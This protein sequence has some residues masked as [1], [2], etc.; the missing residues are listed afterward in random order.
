MNAD[1]ARALNDEYARQQ[2]MDEESINKRIRSA[3]RD[4]KSSIQV[5]L[6]KVDA[7]YRDRTYGKLERSFQ[8]RGFIVKRCKWSGDQRDPSGYDYAVISW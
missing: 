7:S 6:S 2:Q 3:A 1:E 8:D 5:D 4:G